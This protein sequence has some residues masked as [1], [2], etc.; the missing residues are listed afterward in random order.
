MNDNVKDFINQNADR[1]DLNKWDEIYEITEI[2]L[3]DNYLIGQFTEVIR[4]AGIDP[5][6]YLKKVPYG[7]L[8]STYTSEIIIPN[9]IEYISSCAFLDTDITEI[10]IPGNVKKIYNKAFYEC[11]N[12]RK[13]IIDEG[14]TY[15]ASYVF[16]SCSELK[17]LNLPSTLREI[18]EG[19]FMYCSNLPETLK[20]PEGLELIRGKAFISGRLTPMKV[21]LPKSLKHFAPTA[22]NPEDILVVYAGSEAEKLAKD[23]QYTYEVI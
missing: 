18:G 21:Y 7:Y 10:H 2:G 14:L 11:D 19:C 8:A 1:I 15:L 22:F 23:F 3:V 4:E 5:L 20:L 17:E 16:K 9:H 13:V 6:E 12:L